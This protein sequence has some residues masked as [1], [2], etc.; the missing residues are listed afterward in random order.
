MAVLICFGRV[1]SGS[2]LLLDN[3]TQAKM[4]FL[5]GHLEGNR[6]LSDIPSKDL[7]ISLVSL[8]FF[9]FLGSVSQ[10]LGPGDKDLATRLP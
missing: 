7:M 4:R 10:L 1:C 5:F 8:C 3:K 2:C 6:K 9:G